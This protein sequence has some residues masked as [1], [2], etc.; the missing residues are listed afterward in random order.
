ML[1]QFLAIFGLKPDYDLDIMRPEQDL[2]DVTCNALLGLKKAINADRPDLVLVQG[3]TTTSL[4]GAMAAFY[5][6]VPVAHIEAGLRTFDRTAPFPE[7]AN[8][9]MI[10]AITDL[11]FP[12]TSTSRDNLLRENVPESRIVVTGNTVI[13]AL[14]WMHARVRDR[15]DWGDTFGS[16]RD[17]IT[18]DK[19]LLLVTGHRRENFGEG[20]KSI[21]R[22][23]ATLAA[24]HP[25]W[26][27]VYPVH[28]NPNVQ[29]PVREI[30]GKLA[31][32]HLIS[33]LD[34]PAFV[35][36]MSRAKLIVTDSGGVQE[37]APSLGKPVLVMRDTTERP[38]A[39][40]AGTAILVGTDEGRI[41]AHV[42]ALMTDSTLYDRMARAHNPYGDG[43]ASERI[44]TALKAFTAQQK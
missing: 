14:F 16:A 7:E 23:L 21:C 33:P 27:L 4:A 3:D 18:S 42:E 43:H 32:V 19:P 25:D 28:L 44:A 39:L 41:V 12:P 11:H 40:E 20:F 22:A 36:L 34:Y 17:A 35:Y 2:F 13:D 1:D 37:E 29:R 5:L 15:R 6:R 26:N 9:T 31:N 38:E 24:R 8:R 30:L 10:S